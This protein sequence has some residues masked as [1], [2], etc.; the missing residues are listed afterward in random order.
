MKKHRIIRILSGLAASFAFVGAT[1][2]AGTLTPVVSGQKPAEIL[3]HQVQVVIN[4]GFAK[5]EVIQR[6]RN[7]NA[8]KME[9]L[10]S[11]PLPKS[12]SL[13]EVTVQ[14]GEELING[15]VV[16]RKTADR[17][18]G[19][20]KAKGASAAKAE[21]NGYEDFTFSIANLAA[22]E[23]AQIRF[24]YYQPLPVDTG[25]VS[26]VYPL[27]E[28]N[29]RDAVAENFWL[30]NSKVSGKTTVQIELR[31]AWALESVRS[32]GQ[33]PVA[34]T[35][36]L[37]N[38]V[39]KLEYELKDGL[40]GDFVFHYQ[41]V[42]LPGRLEV[43][44]YRAPGAK[45]GTFMMVL[46]PGIDLKPIERGADYV[47]VLDV[48]GSMNGQKIRTLCDGVVQAIGKMQP[49]DRFRIVTF[50]SDAAEI[51]RDWVPAEP[52]SV[53]HWSQKIQ[54]LQA[55]GGTNLYAGMSTAL[56]RVNADRVTSIVLVTDA[57]TNVGQITPKSFHD[58]LKEKDVRVFG[59]LMGNSANWPLMQ[60]ICETSGGFYA[61]VSNSDDIIGKIL[62]AKSKICYEALHDAKIEINGVKTAD[63]T[64]QAFKKLYRGQ[65]MVAFGR[66][67]GTGKAEITFQAKLSGRQ[68]TYHCRINFP[69]TDTD[70]PE[71]ERLWAMARIEQIEYLTAI[72]N[73]PKSEKA[74]MISDLGVQYQLVTDETSML[75]L[76]DEAF[77]THGVKRLNQAR[78]AVE[79]AAQSARVAAPIRNYRVDVPAPQN[80]RQPHSQP[81][82]NN[83]MFRNNAPRLG[84]GAVNWPL[85]GIALLLAGIAVTRTA[86]KK[87]V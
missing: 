66:Y 27:E 54:Q 38:G 2:G 29:T 82:N 25:V 58:L 44:P 73:V 50:S 84:G 55:G 26:Y 7:N 14:H 75:V 35:I 36:D 76:T 6:F 1:F 83:S 71:L 57:V 19:E 80:N 16:E 34:S 48:S 42:E 21:K 43:I 45:E 5:T 72:G 87:E 22:G 68:E 52:E 65:Q 74:Q 18:Y 81:A 62:Q 51:T 30:R 8:E 46:T 53:Q 37:P 49:H 3:S 11:F 13:S 78:V 20:E 60:T 41:L 63:L 70:N 23:E 67:L 28:G 69:E 17:I 40:A 31:S 61:G 79:H 4:N 24:V 59:F 9:A 64:G 39:A 85:L 56:K 10:Y 12:A 47:F 86:F 33:N 15:E 32:P 77:R